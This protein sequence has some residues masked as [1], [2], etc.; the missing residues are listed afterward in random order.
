MYIDDVIDIR[1]PEHFADAEEV[2]AKKPKRH[3]IWGFT[4]ERPGFCYVRE[5][6]S[7]KELDV[8]RR[9]TRREK[10]CQ[11]PGDILTKGRTPEDVLEKTFK[12]L[13][14]MPVDVG[15]KIFTVEST[16]VVEKQNY[17]IDVYWVKPKDYIDKETKRAFYRKFHRV[18][19]ANIDVIEKVRWTP[20]M[21]D[22][23]NRLYIPMMT[24]K[25][26]TGG[27]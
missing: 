12:I 9:R 8:K 15:K 20:I 27:Y 24:R 19:V 10:W 2:A 3:L 23:Y 26:E 7:P 11:L 5:F 14:D 4:R 22:F 17:I 13:Y 18:N 21:K 16:D 1:Y 6:I 25:D